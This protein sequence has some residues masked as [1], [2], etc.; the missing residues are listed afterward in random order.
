MEKAEQIQLNVKDKAKKAK[1]GLL[2]IVFSRSALIVLLLLVQVWL[3]FAPTTLFEQYARWITAAFNVLRMFAIIYIINEKGNPAFKMTWILLILIAPAAGT[4]FYFFVKL[5]PG[6]KYTKLRLNVLENE[7]KP[8]LKQN[9]AIVKSLRVSKPANGNLAHYMSHQIDFPVYR[10]T[11]AVYFPLGEDKF[12]ELK[13]Q[14]EKAEKFIFLEYFIVE[15]G[16]MWNSVLEILERKVRQGVEVRFLYDGMCS[17]FQLPYNYPKEMRRCGIK[18]KIA[19]PIRPVLS[20][21]QNNRDHRK[22]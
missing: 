5:Q 15:E 9:P 20:S 22:I 13:R 3:F 10:N 12:E 2:S 14:L 4:A 17:M 1:R 6:T 18:C 16:V 11:S 8:Y 19:N 21:T 7:I